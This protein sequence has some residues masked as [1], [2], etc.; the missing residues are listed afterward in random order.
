MGMDTS[1]RT[2]AGVSLQAGAYHRRSIAHSRTRSPL[3]AALMVLPL[4][5]A[6]ACLRHRPQILTPIRVPTF[7][8][9]APMTEVPVTP[10]RASLVEDPLRRIDRMDWPGPNQ[11]RTAVGAPGP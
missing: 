5:V 6:T 11:Y 1:R 3:R 8:L 4:F 7:P 10:G 2:W 9:T